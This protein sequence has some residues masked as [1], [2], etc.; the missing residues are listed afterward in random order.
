MLPYLPPAYPDE[1][2]YSL[3]ARFHRH[4]GETSPKRTLD[5]LPLGSGWGKA[6][7]AFGRTEPSPAGGA[8]FDT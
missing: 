7:G 6:P 1:L 4:I 2:L 5:M 3:L 8:P